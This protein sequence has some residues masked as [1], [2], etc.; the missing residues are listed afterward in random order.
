MF[1]MLVLGLGCRTDVT[2]EGTLVGNAGGTKGKLMPTSGYSCDTPW[3]PVNSLQLLNVQGYELYGEVSPTDDLLQTGVVIPPIDA[4]SVHIEMGNWDLVCTVGEENTLFNFV[5][6]TL[7]LKLGANGFAERMI[8]ALGENGWLLAPDPQEKLE[9]TS[10]LWNDVNVNGEI[11]DS[12]SVLAQSNTLEEEDHE[13]DNED[14]HSDTGDDSHSEESDS[15]EE[16]DRA[17]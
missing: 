15:A 3:I 11:D 4:S 1:W 13:D 8:L 17:E 10:K 5:S 2:Y 12:D 7:D 9:Q 6:P 14:D 16:E